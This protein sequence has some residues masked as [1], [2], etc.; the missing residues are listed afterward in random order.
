MPDDNVNQKDNT[1]ILEGVSLGSVH[2]GANI[3]FDP[4][5]NITNNDKE[6]KKPDKLEDSPND[7]KPGISGGDIK[8]DVEKNDGNNDKKDDDN[9]SE[10]TSIGVEAF[11]NEQGDLVDKESKIIRKK[12]EFQIDEKSGAVSYTESATESILNYYR[13]NGYEFKDENGTEI[14]FD[15]TSESLNRINE[16]VAETK[17]KKQ[18]EEFFSKLPT[19]NEFYL[20]LASGGKESDFFKRKAELVDYNNINV[21]EEDKLTRKA[22]IKDWL[23]KVY[24]NDEKIS[25]EMLQMFEDS[26]KID[27]KYTEAIAALK[28]WQN[29]LEQ[30]KNT[31]NQLVL[32]EQSKRVEEYWKNIET[33]ISKGN[34]GIISIPDTEKSN[35]ISYLK[36]PI[37]ENMSQADINVNKLTEEQRLIIDYLIYK[38]FNLDKLIEVKAATLQA[39]KLGK[40]VTI[41]PTVNK[42]PVIQQNQGINSLDGFN[43][44]NLS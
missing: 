17:S 43:I 23:T 39:N 26:G 15:D 28:T 35:F 25:G 14:K 27:E 37:K 11:V 13:T 41:I 33:V 12:G 31:K 6:D 22:V 44:N 10:G 2:E 29:K 38:D 34:L 42:Q 5:Q 24:G 30:D 40:K 8:T 18:I 36:N 19:V 1:N 7:I 9:P 32:Q 4:S 16:I 20:H 21:P 3:N